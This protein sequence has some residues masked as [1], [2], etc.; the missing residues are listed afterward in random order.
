MSLVLVASW[1]AVLRQQEGDFWGRVVCSA[2]L[3][4]SHFQA[5]VPHAASAFVPQK[6]PRF[7][8][9]FRRASVF[10]NNCKRGKPKPHVLQFYRHRPVC[11]FT[12]VLTSICNSGGVRIYAPPA[13]YYWIGLLLWLPGWRGGSSALVPVEEPL[14]SSSFSSG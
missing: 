14:S 5:A 10:V 4:Q 9:D 3:S 6:H 7:N 1:N 2:F 11:C 13:I 8:V 12:V